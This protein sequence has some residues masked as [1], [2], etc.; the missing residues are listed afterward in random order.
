M[1]NWRIRDFHSSDMDGILHLWESL[2][3]DNVHRLKFTGGRGRSWPQS[4]ARNR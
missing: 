3:A 4:L 1:T 2:K